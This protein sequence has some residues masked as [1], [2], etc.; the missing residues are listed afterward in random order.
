MGKWLRGR[1][2]ASE[3][4]AWAS[5]DL[6]PRLRGLAGPANKSKESGPSPQIA[7]RWYEVALIV[8]M[9]RTGTGGG[10]GLVADSGRQKLWWFGLVWFGLLPTL[11]YR[12]PA[13]VDRKD[14]FD[15]GFEV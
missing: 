10:D 9:A 12:R 4:K 7:G 14:G 6:E 11:R 5:L 13:E 8:G 1:H 3:R 2:G 15:C